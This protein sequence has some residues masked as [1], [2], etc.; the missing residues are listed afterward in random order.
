MPGLTIWV[1]IIGLAALGFTV[2]W[3]GP[4]VGLE[5]SLTGTFAG[6]LVGAAAALFGMRLERFQGKADD[7]L[8]ETEKG[9]KIKTLIVAELVNVAAGLIAAKRFMQAAVDT[10]R[11]GGPVPPQT[12]LT[13]VMPRTMPFTAV[14]GTEL[15]V[16]PEPQI[17]ILA[18]L[19]SDLAA[20]RQQMAEVSSG[21]RSFGL[22]TATALNDGIAHSM[23]LLADAFASL[24]PLR[25]LKID[26]QPAASASIV[27]R[28]LA[29]VEAA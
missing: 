4:F 2:P 17:D 3:I 24:A 20:T 22:L 19:E 12:D 8:R 9:T 5:P 13:H 26:G 27:L 11:A 6:A 10:I 7:A 16:L 1:V 25:Q 18:T 14:L 28:R 23:V 15:L 29:G 21:G